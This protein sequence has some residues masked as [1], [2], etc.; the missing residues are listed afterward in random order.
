MQHVIFG[1]KLI[2][3]LSNPKL[4]DIIRNIEENEILHEI[5]RIVQYLVF[6]ATSRVI[7]R[8]IDYLWDIV[9][10]FHPDPVLYTVVPS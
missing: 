3:F 9:L 7:S 8:K 10:L 5:F 4:R 1:F 2:A 6:S